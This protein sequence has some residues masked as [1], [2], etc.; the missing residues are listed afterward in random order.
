M[1]TI[2]NL[3]DSDQY[4]IDNLILDFLHSWNEKDEKAYASLFTENAEYT[5][6]TNETYSGR[7]TIAEKHVYPF[8][9]INKNATLSFNEIRLRYIESGII[10]FTARWTV[11]GSV[12]EKGNKLSPR[13]GV[14]NAVIKIVE[15]NPLISH[16][17]NADIGQQYFI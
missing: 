5:A 15:N 3:N 17:Y 10:F 2:S 16:S 8:T 11:K 1:K 13:N 7:K 12:D 14:L 4:K 9:V 6:V